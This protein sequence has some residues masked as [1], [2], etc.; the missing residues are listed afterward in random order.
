MVGEVG[1]P[2]GSGVVYQGPE[3]QLLACIECHLANM[4]RTA[5][6]DLLITAI[7]L[8]ALILLSLGGH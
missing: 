4:E 7:G 3:A 6:A 2:D 1:M 8:S 5:R